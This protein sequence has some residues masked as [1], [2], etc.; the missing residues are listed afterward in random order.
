MIIRSTV[1]ELKEACL[2]RGI[3]LDPN[4]RHKK[5]DL[6]A[7][8]LRNA[9]LEGRAPGGWGANARIGVASPQLCFNY[10]ELT[11]DER[12]TVL[13]SPRWI[14]EP[15]YYGVR[16]L[17]S[18][19][20]DEGF[21]IWSRHHDDQTFWPLDY[22]EKLL[23]LREGRMT[24]GRD[25]RGAFPEPFLVDGEIYRPGDRHGQS[26]HGRYQGVE[27]NYA[28][29]V[30][31]MPVQESVTLQAER[32]TLRVVLFDCLH[33]GTDSV[34][35]RPLEE[36]KQVLRELVAQGLPFEEAPY[37]ERHK[38]AFFHR[39]TARGWEGVVF[40][41][42]DKPYHPSTRRHRD[43][44]VRLR[45]GMET[46]TPLEELD[47][48]VSGQEPGDRASLKVSV[49]V[50]GENGEE[51]E[52]CVASVSDIPDPVRE[53]FFEPHSILGG[54]LLKPSAYGKVLTLR[55]RGFR[56]PE[57][58]FD[59]AWVDWSQGIRLDKTR[60]DCVIDASPL[61]SPSFELCHE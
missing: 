51:R 52:H 35:N 2:R 54:P 12:E 39:M 36:R 31:R 5:A 20:P 16:T 56:G 14:A 4:A 25:W 19:H 47:V 18:Y 44:Q 61:F 8:L 33:R 42:L 37:T 26:P 49:Y 11:P 21:R 41:N 38:R 10:S 6:L 57:P 58:R 60:Y 13:D 32:G 46:L 15:K 50:R 24:R 53:A 27:I 40:K 28:S 9:V 7:E 45:P 3:A 30:L 55:V 23:I 43:V 1:S 48:F 34:W 17:V 59:H 29:A 22:G